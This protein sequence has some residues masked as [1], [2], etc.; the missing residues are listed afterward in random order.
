MY[1]TTAPLPVRLFA[2]REE[3]YSIKRRV[4]PHQCLKQ[5]FCVFGAQDGRFS[6][7]SSR[8][9]KTIDA[10]DVRRLPELHLFDT[11]AKT[12][13]KLGNGTSPC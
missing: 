5:D 6:T 2:R 12:T 1:K 7:P 9:Y 8:W 3:G 10:D 4:H 11:H 13:P